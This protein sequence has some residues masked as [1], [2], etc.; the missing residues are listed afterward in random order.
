MGA[1]LFAHCTANN[2]SIE[3]IPF[4]LVYVLC[5]LMLKDYMVHIFTQEGTIVNN[6]IRVL[7]SKISK[8][9]KLKETRL[10]LSEN[11]GGQ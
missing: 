6:S 11:I 2:I 10:E 3:H 5:P 7:T 8:L 1:V 9:E 4:Q